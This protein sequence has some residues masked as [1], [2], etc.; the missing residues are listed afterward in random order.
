MQKANFF[1]KNIQQNHHAIQFDLIV[2]NE[3][4]PKQTVNLAGI[5]QLENL[6]CALA[7]A[8]ATGIPISSMIPSLPL[9]KSAKG[10]ME[11]VASKNGVPIFVDDNSCV[12]WKVAN[13]DIAQ[14]ESPRVFE[15][16][17]WLYD[18]ASAHWSDADAQAGRIWQKFLPYLTSTITS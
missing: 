16:E 4:F 3:I 11:Y 8:H 18:L 1:A 9:L 5:F 10:R 7:L 17:Q 2:Y 15:R 12:S 6:L 14:I 13:R